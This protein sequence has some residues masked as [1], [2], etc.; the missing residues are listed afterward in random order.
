MIWLV[1]NACHRIAPNG[2]M[3]CILSFHIHS[4]HIPLSS[5]LSTSIHTSQTWIESMSNP[6]ILYQVQAKAKQIWKETTSDSYH[7]LNDVLEI[8]GVLPNLALFQRQNWRLASSPP[9]EPAPVPTVEPAVPAPA[10]A[11]VRNWAMRGISGSQTSP[12]PSGNQD[13]LGE[14]VSIHPSTCLY[15][16]LYLGI[17]MHVHVEA[18]PCW[19]PPS[20][21]G[22]QPIQG[23][24]M[25]FLAST[26]AVSEAVATQMWQPEM[27]VKG[28]S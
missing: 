15:I 23:D 4:I 26:V 24:S 12:G 17:Q 14:F 8:L 6:H 11:A 10:E 21:A 1:W 16:Y 19:S 3:I 20:H 25:A 13:L 5:V 27:P 28:Q 9:P 22:K 2:I 18:A 7:F